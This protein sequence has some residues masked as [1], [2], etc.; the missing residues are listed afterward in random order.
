MK[1]EKDSRPRYT[2]TEWIKLARATHGQQY[3]YENTDYLGNTM[4]VTVTCAV[5]GDFQIR[6]SNHLQGRGCPQCSGGHSRKRGSLESF[7]ERATAIH[8]A[9]YDYSKAR[10]TN[11]IT[12]VRIVCPTHGAF[13]KTPSN[14]LAGQGCMKCKTGEKLSKKGK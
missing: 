8:G 4:N 7:I 5:H 11:A 12:A 13:R 6:P 14:H 2:T 10:Y 9:M 1:T 3:D